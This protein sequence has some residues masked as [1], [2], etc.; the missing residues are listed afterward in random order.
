MSMCCGFP[1]AA[2]FAFENF[3]VQRASRSFW[4]SLAGLSF[5]HLAGLD[6]GLLV[7][8]ITLLGRRDD[9][10][11]HDLPTHRQISGFGEM[12]VEAGEQVLDRAGLDQMLAKQPDRLGIRDLVGEAKSD[13][14]HEREPILDLELGLVV[15]EVV[16]RLKDQN[17]EHQ[18][19]IVWRPPALGAVRALQR[20]GKRLPEDL[21]RNERVQLLERIAGLAQAAIALIDVPEPRLTTHPILPISIR[22]ME[23]RIAIKGEVLRCLQVPAC[24]IRL[25]RLRAPSLNCG[26]QTERVIR[27]FT[28]AVV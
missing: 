5:R 22:R 3:T 16:Q 21:S 20:L 2:G 25:C 13:E 19:G 27:L 9:R 12:L 10:G 7:L 8:G 17:L 23:S 6:R 26:S 24:R 11:I 15:G 18:D 4:R 14:T 1:S 28:V